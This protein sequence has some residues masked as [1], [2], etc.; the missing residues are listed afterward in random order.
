MNDQ[1]IRK[2]LVVLSGP[3]GVG[4]GTIVDILKGNYGFMSSVSCTTR[5]PREGEVDGVAYFF[6]TREEFLALAESGEMLEYDEHFGNYYGTPKQYVVDKLKTDDVILEIEVN[7][8][9]NVKK[10][11][12]EALLIMITPPSMDELKRRLFGRG[13][14]TAEQIENRMER[15]R[16]ELSKQ[17]EYDY[18]VVNDKLDETVAKIL[19]IIETE[20]RKNQ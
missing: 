12:P 6:K 14:E 11:M 15:I 9:L 2:M 1:K 8:A 17:N 16:Y 19:E 20:R 5:K 18:V 4:K 3:S 10:L 7:G 13:T